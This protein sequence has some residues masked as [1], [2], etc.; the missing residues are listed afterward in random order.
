MSGIYDELCN[1]F[2]KPARQSYSE[3]DLGIPAVTQAR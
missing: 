1:L 2:I 3:H